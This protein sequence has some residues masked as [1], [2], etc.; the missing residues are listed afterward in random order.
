MSAPVVVWSQ[1]SQRAKEA[2]RAK[3]GRL[4]RGDQKAKT[5]VPQKGRSP[6][7]ASFAASR[8]APVSQVKICFFGWHSKVYG[9]CFWNARETEPFVKRNFSGV[10]QSPIFRRL[11]GP[12][13]HARFFG[14]MLRHIESHLPIR[15]TR[16]HGSHESH[17]SHG[18]HGSHESHETHE[19]FS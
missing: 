14:Q 9:A 11:L 16:C 7:F 12:S 10:V 17:G 2:K 3:W 5:A 4:P 18:S 13:L 19:P 15:V 6:A 8:W 1:K